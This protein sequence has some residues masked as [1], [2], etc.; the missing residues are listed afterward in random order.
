MAKVRPLK[1]ATPKQAQKT[2][3]KPRKMKKNLPLDSKD[4]RKSA[5]AILDRLQK[6]PS[7]LDAVMTTANRQTPTM[8]ARDRALMQ[9]I[10]YGVLRWQRRLDAVI[11][12]FS[13]TKLNRI[14][15]VILNL[16][17]I[18][19][20]QILYLDR[21]PDSAAVNTTVQM[22]KA[23]APAWVVRYVNGL[24]R[25]AIRNQNDLAIPAENGDIVQT[26]S[27]RKSFPPWL[28][29]RWLE[30]FGEEE[31]IE[32]CDAINTIP[33]ITVRGN[34]LKASR[35]QL[36]E[37]LKSEVDRISMTRFS[38]LG[39]QLSGLHRAV[40]QMAPFQNGIFQVQ[41]EAA[42]L[43]TLILN[44]QPGETILD[45]CAG[46]GGKTGHIAQAMQNQGCLIAADQSSGK[47]S[48]LQQ[49]M[50][51]L[52]IHCVQPQNIDW[53]QPE[54]KVKLPQFDR[55]LIDAPC[56][57]LG[58]IRRNPDT[59]WRSDKSN[60]SRYAR[61]QTV[62]LERIAPLVKP[63]GLVIYAVCS[64]EPEENETV[65]NGFLKNHSEFVK[66]DIGP[67]DSKEIAGLGC[68][69]GFLRTFPH[70][71]TMDGF[72]AARMKKSINC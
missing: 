61:R 24:L 5:L 71:H 29:E 26:L 31:T 40:D 43:V 67:N 42:Q 27:I 2:V 18:G 72:F 13:K 9:T 63:G 35:R 17:R 3:R 8:A 34:T 53:S 1:P 15:P 60:L 55:I 12:H 33:E 47:L 62:F 25:G 44:P 7:T 45:A 37:D 19:M 65:V 16:L 11:A 68:K 23:H 4:A 50:E 57:G 59:K 54:I 21:I 51:R 48:L 38:P 52:G 30:R 41:D 66:E 69:D 32:L 70:Q 20:F 36:M 56:S 49:E 64:F 58:V 28:I 39:L 14:D 6:E 46:L 10:V 22:A